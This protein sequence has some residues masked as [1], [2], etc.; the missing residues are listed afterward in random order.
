MI[1][2]KLNETINELK[3]KFKKLK[4]IGYI[5][6]TSKGRGNIG[7]TFEKLLGKENDKQNMVLVKR[8]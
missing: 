8:T 4:K 7:L 6:S 1:E 5:E 3:E 2:E